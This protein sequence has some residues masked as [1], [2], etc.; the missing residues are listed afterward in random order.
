MHDQMT[1]N[2]NKSIRLFCIKGHCDLDF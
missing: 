1:A 2:S